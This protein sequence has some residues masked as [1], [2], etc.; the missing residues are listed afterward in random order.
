MMQIIYVYILLQII[1]VK[2]YIKFLIS[3]SEFPEKE[4]NS[5]SKHVKP[6]PILLKQSLNSNTKR[7][8]LPLQIL[9]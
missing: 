8:P 7:R 5:R 3:F 6:L 9:S 4:L 2:I 1:Y